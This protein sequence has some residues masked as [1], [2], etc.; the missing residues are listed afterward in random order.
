M[1]ENNMGIKRKDL[2][3]HAAAML[4]GISDGEG[5]EA[6][7][8]VEY[9]RFSLSDKHIEAAGLDNAMPDEIVTFTVRARVQSVERKSKESRKSYD[10]DRVELEVQHISDV[11]VEPA[12][13]KE[14]TAEDEE[15]EK[16][17]GFKGASKGNGSLSPKGAGVKL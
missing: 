7:N 3:P 15:T 17:M 5:K 9:P 6:G 4:V 14:S 10:S 1:A 12:E 13:G 8:E 11:S 16:A 2:K